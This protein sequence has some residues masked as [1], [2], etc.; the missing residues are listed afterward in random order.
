[1]RSGYDSLAYRSVSIRASS[2]HSLSDQQRSRLKM[3]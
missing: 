1:M 3:L 2:A